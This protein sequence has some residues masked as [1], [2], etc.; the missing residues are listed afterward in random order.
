VS[1]NNDTHGLDEQLR[2]VLQ[3]EA[4]RL[5]PTDPLDAGLVQIRRRTDAPVPVA[6]RRW[7]VPV[8]AAAAVLAVVVVGALAWPRGSAAPLVGSS[9]SPTPSAST[10][11]SQTTSPSPSSSPSP[12][13][14]P[15]GGVAVTVGV[16]YGGTFGGRTMLYRE[17]HRTTSEPLT[18]ALQAMLAG[19]ADHDYASLWPR[20]TTLRSVSRSGSTVTVTLSAAPL[21]APPGHGLYGASSVQE[22]VYTVT[23]A[24]ATIHAVTVVYPGGQATAVVRSPALNVLASVWLLTPTDGSSVSSPVTLS[25]TA[26]VFEATVNWEV[27]RADGTVVAQGSAMAPIGAPGRG[28]WST[29][30]TL[31]AGS[32]VAK[33]F[34]IS[35]KDGSITWTDSKAFTVR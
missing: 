9:T 29:T 26:S 16:Y 14:S 12:S 10:S 4:R 3:A 20:G 35:A 15:S 34:A 32:Y 7:F 28:P 30:V 18:G 31:P 19:P 25:G 13:G 17:F 2:R 33:A 27:D 5:D 24:D 1:D 21:V 22:V 6:A 11:L 8:M 23:A